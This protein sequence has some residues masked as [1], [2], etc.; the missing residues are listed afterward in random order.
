MSVIE[1]AFKEIEFKER[2]SAFQ[3]YFLT[4]SEGYYLGYSG[5]VSEEEIRKKEWTLRNTAMSIFAC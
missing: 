4:N 2:W 5:S 1:N 3:L